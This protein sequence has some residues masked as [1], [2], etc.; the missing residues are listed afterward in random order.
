[1]AWRIQ[2]Q[3][4]EFA[5]ERMGVMGGVGPTLS[6]EWLGGH[7]SQF[8][9]FWSPWWESLEYMP[10]SISQGLGSPPSLSLSLLSLP[11]SL[12]LQVTTLVDDV[13]GDVPMSAGVAGEV[14]KVIQDAIEVLPFKNLA[15]PCQKI[16][17]STTWTRFGELVFWRLPLPMSEK[18]L[19][20]SC[21]SF[22]IRF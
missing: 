19:I 4:V 3:R 9:S 14:T 6:V 20:C 21:E 17:T 15:R 12:S 16:R 18:C 7:L 13:F 22:H 11:L 8:D 10:S 2:G 5:T 1:M